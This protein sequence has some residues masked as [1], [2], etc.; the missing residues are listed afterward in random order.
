MITLPLVKSTPEN[1]VPR[2][3]I[4]YGR[5]KVG[6][7]S[8]FCYAPDTLIL[9]TQDGVRFYASTSIQ[10][11]TVEDIRNV[12]LALDAHLKEHGVN[13]YKRIVIDVATD[14]VEMVK[15]VALTNRAA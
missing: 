6:K 9:D 14:M 13:A 12:R 4:I 15:P 5:A 1:Q 10:I 8:I 2:L 11:K 7:S 3:Q